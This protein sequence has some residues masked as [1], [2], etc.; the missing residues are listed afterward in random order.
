MLLL[1]DYVKNYDSEELK[2]SKM[3]DKSVS[4]SE[5]YFLM[6]LAWLI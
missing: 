1:Y 4:T 6:W 2:H 5:E 3:N